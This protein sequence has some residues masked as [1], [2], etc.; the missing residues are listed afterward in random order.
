MEKISK[1]LEQQWDSLLDGYQEEMIQSLRKLIQIRSVFGPEEPDAPY[2]RGSK[3]AFDFAMNLGREKGFD[4]VNFDNRA[5][6]INFGQGEEAAGVISHLDVVPEGEGWTYPPYGGEIHDG[7][8]YGRGA[9]DDKGCFIAAFY[10]CLALKESGVPL[11][12]QIK[13]IVG[14]NEE[15]GVFPCIRHYK[16]VT[17]KM[18][19]CGIVPDAWFPAVYAEKGYW[20]YEFR[21]EFPKETYNDER[22]VLTRFTGG[23]AVNVVIP[24]AKAVFRG[25]SEQFDVV[26]QA[27]CNVIPSER[28]TITQQNDELVLTVAGKSAHGSVPET[29]INAA[30]LLLRLF[31][32]VDFYPL[33]ACETLHVL[34]DQLAF[35]T[36]GSGLNIAYSDDT[37]ALTNNWGVVDMDETHLKASVN[38]RY[39]VTQDLKKLEADLESAA[40]KSGCKCVVTMRNPHFYVDPKLPLIQDLVEIYQDMT[41]DLDSQPVA[42]GGG[43]YA[44]ILENFIPFGPSIQGE[45]LSFHKQDENISCDHLLFLSKIYA[46]A[47]YAMAR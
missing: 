10:A 17:D 45:E 27:A 39:P 3:D 33:D 5:G 14:T 13:Q 8:I 15:L 24:E 30:A 12:R 43:S 4:C 28:L 18:P 16:E 21:K 37:G 19:V 41:G 25:T 38:V 23:A 9:V 46:R 36:D 44:R 29:G 34:A 35:D 11:R 22:P 26:K 2:G 47:L 6:E 42:H 20:I 40:A 7:K 31:K 1:E 32:D